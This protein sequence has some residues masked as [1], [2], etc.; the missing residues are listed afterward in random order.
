MIVP[1]YIR[2]VVR[3]PVLSGLLF[4]CFLVFLFWLFPAGACNSHLIGVTV[5]YIHYPALFFF[6]KVIGIS[7]SAKLFFA[8]ACAMTLVWIVFLTLLRRLFFKGSLGFRGAFKRTTTPP[9]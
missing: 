2:F 1:A 6:E 8:S 5:I 4:E 3:Y 7:Y 9:L